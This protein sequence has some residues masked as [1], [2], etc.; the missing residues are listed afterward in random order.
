MYEL[1]RRGGMG[2]YCE[3]ENTGR[4][5]PISQGK[6]RK[7]TVRKTSE[8]HA[9]CSPGAERKKRFAVQGEA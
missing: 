6:D 3:R 4:F 5:F 9:S 8:S 7:G 1:A 2:F